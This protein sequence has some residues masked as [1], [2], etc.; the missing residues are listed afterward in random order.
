MNARTTQWLVGVAVVL[1]LFILLFERG[2]R[3]TAQRRAEAARLLPGLDPRGVSR[4]EVRVGTNRPVVLER[5]TNNWFFRA[6][7]LYPARPEPVDQFLQRLAEAPV[8]ARISA[9]EILRQTNALAAY[10]LVPP[11]VSL[12]LEGE[13]GPLTLH[14]S[15]PA[16]LGA[17][18]F[19]QIVGRDGLDVVDAALAAALPA[20]WD[21]WRDPSLVNLARLAFDRLEVRPLTNG[22]EALRDP[23]THRW[24]LNKPLPTRANAALLEHLL[25]Q[26]DLLRVARFVADPPVSD[27]ESFGLAPPRRELVFARGTNELLSLRLG[28]APADQPDLLPVWLSTFSNVVL[29]PGT[30]LQP[31]FDGFTNFCDRR[32]MVFDL[33]QVR[34]LEAR[35]DEAFAVE[36]GSGEDWRIVEPYPAPADRL[37]VLEALA[38]MAALEFLGFERE[39]ATDFAPYGL[40][41]PRR[42]YVLRAARTNAS[43]TAGPVLARV[44]YGLPT[45]HRYYARRSLESS[46]VLALDPVRLPR[47]AFQLRDRRL[48]SVSTNDLTAIYVRAQGRERKLVR[49]GPLQW[50]AAEGSGPPP[51]PITLEEAAYRLGQLRAERWVAQGEDKLP[52]Y[53]IVQG[54]H[55]VQ[56]EVRGAAPEPA[57]RVRFGR[58][59]ASGRTYAAVTLPGPPGT[60]VFECPA[61][62]YEFVLSDL[63]LPEP[64]PTPA[65]AP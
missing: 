16:S 51:N 37:L 4:L 38:E 21:A 62:I 58:R 53:G 31:W 64:V 65:A 19:V 33:E 11:A 13:A 32:L 24:T 56:L 1:A 23:V 28:R 34:R 46:V 45:G 22:F 10:G 55:E 25:Q 8:R 43:E 60:V 9:G 20:S 54:A 61:S 14:L 50:A 49:L 5:G 3:S 40:D 27:L 36:R 12:K 17:Q 57:Y 41:P 63:T 30:P 47:A 52:G 2:A 6:P 59:A 42:Q 26:L 39:V 29:V 44:D 15:R 7:V 35:A 48:W 18:V